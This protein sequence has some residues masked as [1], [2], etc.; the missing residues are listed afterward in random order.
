MQY[1]L[2]SAGGKTLRKGAFAQFAES[3]RD[4]P[5][6]PARWI[7]AVAVVTVAA[8]VIAAATELLPGTAFAGLAFAGLLLAAFTVVVV[9]SLARGVDMSC[10]CHHQ[11][12]LRFGHYLAV[13]TIGPDL[14][15]R[16]R[17]LPLPRLTGQIE[18]RD[19]WFRYDDDKPWGSAASTSRFRAAAR[20]PSSA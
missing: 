4:L 13:L 19:V 5:L 7:R 17:P 10:R 2:L 16:T 6:L 15:E 8:E 18:L 9:V 20:P 11:G 1:S 14:P 12:L 3:L